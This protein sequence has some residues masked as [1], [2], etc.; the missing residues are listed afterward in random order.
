MQPKSGTRFSANV[1]V[2]YDKL[3]QGDA[4]HVHN[5]L[6]PVALLCLVKLV[7][8]ADHSWLRWLRCLYSTDRKVSTLFDDLC[9]RH[10]HLSGLVIV[11]GAV[12][13]VFLVAVVG[14]GSGSPGASTQ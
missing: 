3:F 1:F 10:T 5:A 4:T 11:G 14:S 9:S 2:P 7:A 6:A 12:V 8:V 13:V